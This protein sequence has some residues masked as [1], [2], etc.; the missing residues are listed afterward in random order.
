MFFSNVPKT[1]PHLK[2][3]SLK[4]DLIKSIASECFTSLNRD[5]CSESLVEIEELQ[6]FAGSQANYS[7]QTRLLGMEAKLIM[8]IFNM[9]KGK[10]NIKELEDIKAHCGFLY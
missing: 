1:T 6:L 9:P 5:I 2:A 10:F 3:E 8:T 7:C 4:K